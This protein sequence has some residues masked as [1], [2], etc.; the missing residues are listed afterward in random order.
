MERVVKNHPTKKT[1]SNGFTGEFF[2]TLKEKIIPST[3][4]LQENCSDNE[5]ECLLILFY[6]WLRLQLRSTSLDRP[7]T[8]QISYTATYTL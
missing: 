2:Q 4:T 3:K 6:F 5:S 7:E 8:S 1:C